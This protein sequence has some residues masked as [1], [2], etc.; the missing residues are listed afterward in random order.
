EVAN[1]SLHDLT[2]SPAVRFRHEGRDHELRCDA[3][4]GCDG[5]HGVSR[6]SIPAGVPKTYEREYP[7]AWLGIL[8]AV[9]PS[10]DELIYAYNEEGFAL[11]ALRS[12]VI[13]RLYVQ[14][15]PDERIEEWPDE[16]IW[17]TLHR[18]L[19]RDDGWT[20]Q[21][22]PVIEKGIAALRSFVVEPM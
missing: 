6:G 7:F 16:R 21:E 17:Q 4:A 15:R 20:L 8:A 5:F 19:A 1:V 3:V 22:G 18:R 13:S 9:A 11:H 12:P 14:V 2:A 10:T